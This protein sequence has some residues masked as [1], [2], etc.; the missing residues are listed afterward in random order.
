MLVK[1]RHS[2]EA[3]DPGSQVGFTLDKNIIRID[4]RN[5]FYSSNVLARYK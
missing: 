4:N 5:D 1:K 3:A 2:S